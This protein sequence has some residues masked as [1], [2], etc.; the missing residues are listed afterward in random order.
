MGGEREPG[1]PLS[2]PCTCLSIYTRTPLIPLWGY[3]PASLSFSSTPIFSLYSP[4]HPTQCPA[5]S[6]GIP[7]SHRQ[8]QQRQR[9]EGALPGQGGVCE[10]EQRGQQEEGQI[11]WVCSR[12]APPTSTG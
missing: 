8:W 4:K 11:G 3:H 2:P 7:Q 9:Q 10:C 6:H 5:S 1:H 12:L